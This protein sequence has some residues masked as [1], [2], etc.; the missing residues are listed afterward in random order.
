METAT[1]TASPMRAN[2]IAAGDLEQA[3]ETLRSVR[4]WLDG[5]PTPPDVMPEGPEKAAL[6]AELD[7]LIAAVEAA[8]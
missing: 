8:L 6:L 3:L 4:R 5:D 7:A 2:D 1:L